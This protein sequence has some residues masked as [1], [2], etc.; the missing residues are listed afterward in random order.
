[1]RLIVAD[2]EIAPVETS[3]GRY[4][5]VLPPY[6]DR[7]RIRS[8][9]AAPSELR[10]WMDDRRKLGVPICQIVVR[11]NTGSTEV[12]VD[13]PALREGWHDLEQD[14]CRLWRWTDGD[15]VLPLADGAKSVAVQLL[16]CGEYPIDAEILT[17]PSA[18]KTR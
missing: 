14:Q 3:D 17:R 10:P 12:P 9:A 2:R 6:T 13:H 16:G 8:R 1:L 11:D 5:F 18:A 7:A 4:V 15:A